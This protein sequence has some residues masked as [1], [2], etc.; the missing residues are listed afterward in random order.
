[1][2]KFYKFSPFFHS[3]INKSIENIHRPV[4]KQVQNSLSRTRNTLA[5]HIF[6]RFSFQTLV[7]SYRFDRKDSHSITGSEFLLVNEVSS[8]P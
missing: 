6:F 7:G 2:T 5:S 8:T 3:K 1:M 4:Q